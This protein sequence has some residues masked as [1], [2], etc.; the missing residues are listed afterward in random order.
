MCALEATDSAN[1][2]S[3][4][5]L[6]AMND[7]DYSCEKDATDASPRKAELS[8]KIVKVKQSV[9]SVVQAKEKYYKDLE[10]AHGGSGKQESEVLK[11]AEQVNTSYKK[12][13]TTYNELKDAAMQMLE[14]YASRHGKTLREELEA[15]GIEADD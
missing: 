3:V 12:A 10:S 4:N 6:E 11:E 15:R 5:K 13:L 2:D 7:L 1:L 9:E 14:L 8:S